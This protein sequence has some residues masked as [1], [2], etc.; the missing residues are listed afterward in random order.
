MFAM[1]RTSTE[2]LARA[3]APNNTAMPDAPVESQVFHTRHYYSMTLN[4]PNFTSSSGSWVI[5][6]AAADP[7]HADD[8]LEAPVALVKV[9]PAYPVELMKAGVEGNVTLYAVI[10]A[11]GSVGEV[12]VLRGL[13]DRLDEFA[14]VALSAWKFQPAM[15]HGNAVDLDAVVQIPFH[16]AP[17]RQ[18]Y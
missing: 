3:T 9:D 4:M 14:R 6:F 8:D 13:N 17:A 16:P 1:R 18:I 15:R 7:K 12:R 11:D 2:E 10:R 5:R